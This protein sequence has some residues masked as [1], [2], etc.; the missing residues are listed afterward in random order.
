MRTFVGV[1]LLV[2]VLLMVSN[3]SAQDVPALVLIDV[4]L[5]WTVPVYGAVRLFGLEEWQNGVGYTVMKPSADRWHVTATV[6]PVMP[7][8]VWHSRI[9]PPQFGLDLESF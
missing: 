4:D 5:H 2:L 9:F 3:A 6:P 8:D 7:P 1:L